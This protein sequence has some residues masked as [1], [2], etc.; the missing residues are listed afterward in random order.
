MA[1]APQPPHL[2]LPGTVGQTR[3][4]RSAGRDPP[5][6]IPGYRGSRN[7]LVRLLGGCGSPHV[8]NWAAA[9]DGRTFLG[10]R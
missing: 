2:H 9:Q 5:S 6:L 10:G 7:L 4:T 8:R 1:T 3:R